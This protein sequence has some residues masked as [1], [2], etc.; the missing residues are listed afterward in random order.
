MRKI[1]KSKYARRIGILVG[2]CTLF[3]WNKWYQD[4][5]LKTIN[6]EEHNIEIKTGIV[7]QQD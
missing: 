1:K 3:D 4:E 6:E 7:N 2:V 5:M